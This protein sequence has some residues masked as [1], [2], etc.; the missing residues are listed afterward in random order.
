M[1]L[2]LYDTEHYVYLQE[3]LVVACMYI[4]LSRIGLTSRSLWAGE[5]CKSYISE[6]FP[7]KSTYLLSE[8]SQ[9][10]NLLVKFVE[11]YCDG[12]EL[13]D[14]LP[15]IQFVAQYYCLAFTFERPTILK[16][17]PE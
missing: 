9:I 5:Y 17:N 15:S 1:D 8:S 14:T 2:V 16:S 12:L 7:S 6:M 11:F 13:Q 4:C 10:N 3:S